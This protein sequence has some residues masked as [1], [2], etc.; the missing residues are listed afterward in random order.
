MSAPLR[1]WSGQ[2]HPDAMVRTDALR[3]LYA[4][5]RGA[6]TSRTTDAHIADVLVGTA[7]DIDAHG[8]VAPIVQIPTRRGL[9]LA[10]GDGSGM[11]LRPH[12]RGWRL[13]GVLVEHSG[14]WMD[15]P[16]DHLAQAVDPVFGEAW[17]A[18]PSRPRQPDHWA[19]APTG[20][21][22]LLPAQAPARLLQASTAV[23]ADAALALWARL[24]DTI[25]HLRAWRPLGSATM[26]LSTAAS[27]TILPST[28]IARATPAAR[29]LAAIADLLFPGRLGV[30]QD[31]QWAHGWSGSGTL[32][33][34]PRHVASLAR[35]APPSAHALL[36]A[37]QRLEARPD[38][39]AILQ[40][41]L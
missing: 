18:F 9:F 39:L 4:L 40:P 8:P 32:C 12:G 13:P 34:Q 41:H 3:A 25:H 30:A 28:N 19:Q 7:Y 23:W 36:C 16:L 27:P 33:I 10:F 35:P 22:A 17:V 11:A 6:T 14:R 29:A 15:L 31:W 38:V 26:A 1:P 2:A 37:R 20:L 21:E 24:P 5:S